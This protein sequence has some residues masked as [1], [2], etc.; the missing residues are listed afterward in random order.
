MPATRLPATVRQ[1]Y[2]HLRFADDKFDIPS[3]I[4]VLFGADIL[5][6]LI[7]PHADVEHHSGLPSALD[8]QLG[9]IIF[10]SFSTPNKSPPVTLT[11]AI[12][13]PSIED[14][15]KKFWLIEEP[16]APSSP[17]TEDQWCEE[18]F[19]KSTSRDTT[20]RF[21]VALPFRHLFT[22]PTQQ[23]GTS[24]HG[25]GDSRFIA[26]KI[27]YNLEK[28]LAKDPVLYAAYRQFMSTYRSLGHM[29]PAPS[30]GIYFIPH[31]AVFKA[32]GDVSKIR[33]VFDA[34]SASS[35]GRSLND[36]LCTGP[37]L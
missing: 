11:T 1:Q 8:T 25:L 32:D 7:R 9:W 24:R 3:R 19:T 31:H 15:I 23:H 5:P 34:S 33:V 18:Y 37:K 30:P 35:S 17:T 14:L 12:A 27:F 36:I 21:C 2:Q 28:R 4:D 22:G 6:S 20:G 26:L 13:P 29:V 16:A 10:G